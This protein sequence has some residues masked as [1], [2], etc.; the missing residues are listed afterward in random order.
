MYII[1]IYIYICAWM[2]H[3]GG[4]HP[5]DHRFTDPSKP[6]TLSMEELQTLNSSKAHE[7]SHGAKACKAAGAP[8]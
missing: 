8:P 2:L 6:C 3:A 4:Y 5:P 1:Q 7:S